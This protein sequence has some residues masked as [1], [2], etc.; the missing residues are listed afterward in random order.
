MLTTVQGAAVRGSTSNFEPCTS[1][2]EGGS[3]LN[4]GVRQFEGSRVRNSNCWDL[5]A[6]SSGTRAPCFASPPGDSFS[7]PRSCRSPS[8]PLRARRNQPGRFEPTVLPVGSSVQGCLC[9][10][11]ARGYKLGL[12]RPLPFDKLRAIPGRSRYPDAQGTSP[13]GRAPCSAMASK[14]PGCSWPRRIT[15][16][17]IASPLNWNDSRCIL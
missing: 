2:T 12:T 11:G 17:P 9:Q 7:G 14:P 10:S 16:H 6:E 5:A 3:S 1:N 4:K 8:S 13:R 15:F